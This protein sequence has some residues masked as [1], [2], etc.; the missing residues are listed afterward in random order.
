MRVKIGG[1]AWLP[2]DELLSHQILNIKDKLTVYP[3]KTTDIASKS[4]PDPIFMYE[5]ND[6]FLG[7]PRGWYLK[8][9]TQGHDEVLDIS[10]GAQMK[11]MKTAYRADGPFVEQARVLDIFESI[12]S[13]KHDN[14]WGG[15]L[16]QASCGAGKTNVA[17]E[18]AR[19]VGRRTLVLVHQEFFLDQWRDRI[20]ELMP[21]ATVGIIRQNKCEYEGCD[22]SIGMLQSLARDDGNKY[23]DELYKSVFGTII[24]DE[25]HRLPA[26]T[27]ASILPRFNAAWRI[28]LSATPKRKDGAQDV[29]FNHISDITYVA[30]IPAQV[31]K[32]RVLRTSSRLKPIRR[33]TYHVPTS[34]LN[35]AQILTQLGGDE[36]RAKD[37]AD[38]LVLAVQAGRKVMVVSERIA[39]LKMMSDMLIESL[40]NMD[41]PFIPR[42][43]Y[44]TGEWYSDQLWTSD[45]KRPKGKR[46]G[47]PKLVKRTKAELLRTEGANVIMGT[48]QLISEGYD[49]PA[50]DVLVLSLPMSDVEQVVGRVRRWCTAESEKCNRLCPWR[51]GDCKEKPE[52]IVMDVVDEDIPQ[53]VSKWNRR[54]RFYGRIGTL[55]KRGKNE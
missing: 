29:F 50:L 13:E 23:P 34:K 40:F 6:D 49:N 8:N 4:E 41:L 1:W 45:E 22:F 48:K 44:Y 52:P 54:Q 31:P 10:Y 38:Q 5:E 30:N 47:D 24:V 21:D 32:L 27:F 55:G 12:K 42:V 19:R 2:K 25:C 39:H 18:F 15:F 17:I 16:L 11:D 35:S 36:F 26:S 51:A 20:K 28:G 33:G 46:P 3:R 53:L 9:V 43:D 37:V 7:V 14:R